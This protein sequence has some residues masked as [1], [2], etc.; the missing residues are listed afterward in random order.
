MSKH[1]HI[2]YTV[3]AQGLES[4]SKLSAKY[5]AEELAYQLSEYYPAH[6]IEVDIDNRK[7]K[8]SANYSEDIPKGEIENIAAELWISE[9]WPVEAE[10]ET[11]PKLGR[12]PLPPG[13]AKTERVQLKET[14]ARKAA[15]QTNAAAAGMSLQEWIDWKCDQP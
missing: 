1:Q 2:K 14:P 9:A 12:K 13:E 15:W 7:T 8:P 6:E 5:Y 3:T 10:G 11:K 4:G